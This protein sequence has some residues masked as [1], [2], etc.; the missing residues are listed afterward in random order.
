[1][2]SRIPLALFPSYG[3]EYVEHHQTQM[4]A[5]HESGLDGE[6]GEDGRVYVVLTVTG[7][8]QPLAPRAYE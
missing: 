1:M 2:S 4:K 5:P 7:T 3:S 8:G 6:A